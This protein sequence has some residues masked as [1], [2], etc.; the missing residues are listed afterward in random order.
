MP[1]KPE[2]DEDERLRRELLEEQEQNMKDAVTDLVYEQKLWEH[3]D[4]DDWK[5]KSFMEPGDDDHHHY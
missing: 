5:F 3:Y 1:R 2:P 4:A